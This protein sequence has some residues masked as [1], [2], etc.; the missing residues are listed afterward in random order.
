MQYTLAGSS[1]GASASQSSV[2][3]GALVQPRKKSGC[4]GTPNPVLVTWSRCSMS[5]STAVDGSHAHTR[6]HTRARALSH[7]AAHHL[8]E[9]K[10]E[11]KQDRSFK[12]PNDEDLRELAIWRHFVPVEEGVVR[13]RIGP[14]VLRCQNSGTDSK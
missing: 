8:V 5:M 6:S 2:F 13:V 3:F 12:R 4:L 1:L 9:V 10:R 7:K 11:Q 14:L